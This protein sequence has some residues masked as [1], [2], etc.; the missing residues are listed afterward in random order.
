MISCFPGL[1]H[2]LNGVGL[3]GVVALRAVLPVPRVVARLAVAVLDL[4]L[5]VALGPEKARRAGFSDQNTLN[6]SC[7]L[8]ITQNRENKL[9]YTYKCRNTRRC[10]GTAKF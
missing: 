3:R 10:T 5:R 6:Y 7:T 4:V 2:C 1:Q 8:K 9:N